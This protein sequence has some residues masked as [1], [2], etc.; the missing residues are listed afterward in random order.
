MQRCAGAD[1][2]KPAMGVNTVTPRCRICPSFFCPSKCSPHGQ[3]WHSQNVDALW[4]TRGWCFIFTG[5]A[6]CS[7]LPVLKNYVGVKDGGNYK[8]SYVCTTLL[9]TVFF[10]LL[11][12]SP[13]CY[14]LSAILFFHTLT[15][16]KT[17]HFSFLMYHVRSFFLALPCL[18]CNCTSPF[19]VLLFLPHTGSQMAVGA[20]LWGSELRQL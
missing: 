18:A 20:F 11:S 9:L 2:G 14:H 16:L 6:R 7:M 3:G 1:A 12:K 8:K 17:T 19:S 4:R 5:T 15:S 13:P 10:S